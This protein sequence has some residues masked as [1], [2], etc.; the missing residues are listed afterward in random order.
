[1]RLNVRSQARVRKIKSTPPRSGGVG[2]GRVSGDRAPARPR[3]RS[4][5]RDTACR[6]TASSRVRRFRLRP[7]IRRGRPRRPERS[8]LS[9]GTAHIARCRARALRGATL[10]M[11][12]RIRGHAASRAGD[13]IASRLRHSHARRS[14]RASQPVGRIRN[15]DIASALS[16]ASRTPMQKAPTLSQ[17]RLHDSSGRA[18]ARYRPRR[19]VLTGSNC[20]SKCRSAISFPQ[21]HLSIYRSQTAWRHTA[22]EA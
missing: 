21:H 12:F 18:T 20:G 3:S 5:R 7:S 6:S 1:M 2:P 13:L 11:P 9:S 10:S 8:G 16:S 19:S 14:S 15:A 17:S 22:A 4:S